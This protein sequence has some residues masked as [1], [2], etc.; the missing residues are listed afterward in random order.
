MGVPLEGV[1][2]A[3]DTLLL[4]RKEDGRFLTLTDVPE[5]AEALLPAPADGKSHLSLQGASDFLDHFL[6]D[7]DTLWRTAHDAQQRSGPWVEVDEARSEWPFEATAIS[8]GGR[9]FLLLRALGDE[10]ERRQA[11]LQAAHLNLLNK[12]ELE[13]RVDERTATLRRREE[14]IALRLTTACGVRDGETGGHIR[15]IGLYAVAMTRALGWSRSERDDIRIAA[16]MHDIGK[17][18][19]PDRILLKP[20]RLTPLERQEMQRH[21]EI[22][23]SM[24]ACQDIPLL[25]MAERIAWSHH[26]RWDGTGY[27]RGLKGEQIPLPARIT[28]IVDVYDAMIHER[29]YK[30]AIPE[31]KVLHWMKKQ[32]GKMFDPGLLQLFFGLLPEIRRIRTRVPDEDSEYPSSLL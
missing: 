5:W 30:P 6:E 9:A 7:A 14:E 27:P 21:A 16:P 19:I 4:E 23:A 24:L 15:R 13:R 29:I 2:A 8:H 31:A 28:T 18:G 22:G 12:E 11:R 1:T 17:I 20:G 26:E 3:L 25:Q 32:S 10:Y